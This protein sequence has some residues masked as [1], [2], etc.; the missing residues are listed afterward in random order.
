MELRNIIEELKRNHPYPEDIFIVLGEKGRRAYVQSLIKS[1]LN[2]DRYSAE[3]MRLG[4][5]NCIIRLE[6]LIKEQ[7]KV[8]P[9]S[10]HDWSHGYPLA[11][12]MI[13]YTS[14]GIGVIF[15]MFMMWIFIWY[16]EKWQ[17]KV[18]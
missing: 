11:I 12:F 3:L 9:N 4:W 7:N 17:N 15:G 5:K 2:V 14:L 10:S 16:K 1:N 6:Q 13:D 8:K 18:V